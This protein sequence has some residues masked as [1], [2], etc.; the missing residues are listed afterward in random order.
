M[1]AICPVH[2]KYRG[3]RKPTTKKQCACHTYWGTLALFSV[4]RRS[5]KPRR[6]PSI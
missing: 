6:E 5:K 1:S 2:P 3:I 4:L